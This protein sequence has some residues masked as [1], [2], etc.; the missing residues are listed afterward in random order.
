MI[1][2]ES[3]PAIKSF[4]RSLATITSTLLLTRVMA[5]FLAPHRRMS[6]TH[7]ASAI[8]TRTCHRA[9]LGRYL[10][11]LGRNHDWK[12]ATPTGRKRLRRLLHATHPVE[13]RI[14]A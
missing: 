11:R 4:A 13:Y 12:L 9:N 1:F 6:A 7:A 8:R 3:L 14:R 5:G 10:A 2:L